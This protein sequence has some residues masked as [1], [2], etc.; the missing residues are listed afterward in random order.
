MNLYSA[1]LAVKAAMM[2]DTA[3]QQHAPCAPNLAIP[4][5]T[6]PSAH[7]ARSVELLDTKK[8]N[9]QPSRA[10]SVR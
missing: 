6:A 2:K 1:S 7:R 5:S 8:R 3:Q 10:A 9:A 4:V